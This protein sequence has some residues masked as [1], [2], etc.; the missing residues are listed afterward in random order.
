MKFFTGIRLVAALIF[1]P[2]ALAAHARDFDLTVGKHEVLP[3]KVL[4]EDRDLLI[5]APQKPVPNMPLLV[6]LDGEWNFRKV[7]VAAENL[8][9]NNLLPPTV[10]VGVANTNRGRDLM[11]SFNGGEFAQGPSDRFLSFLADELIPH[12]AAE[13]SI[14]KFHILAGHSN[15]GMFSLYA[16]IRRPEVFQANIVLS[17]SYGLDDHFVALLARALASP[18]AEQHFVFIGAGGDEEADI[19]VG[20]MR[21]AKTFEGAP[22]PAIE[23]HYEIFPGETHGSVGFRAFYRALEAIG[24]ADT[25]AHSGPARYLSEAQRRR[26]AWTRRFGSA[27]ETQP[28]PL[29]SVAR[30]LLDALAAS[31][32]GSLASTWQLLQSDYKDDF[33]FDS[34]ERANLLAALEA[35]GKKEDA[36]RLRSLPGFADGL[37]AAG[38]V[39]NDYGDA[40]HLDVGLVA[41]LPLAGPPAD[42][43]HPDSKPKI[44]GAVPAPDRHDKAD[45][46]WRFSGN[47]D[48]LEFPANPD[49]ATADSV[50]VSAWIR[51]HSPS[52]YTAWVSQVSSLGWGSQWRMGFGPTPTS[53][54]GATTFNGRWSDYLVNG[55]GLPVDKW[56]HT[57]AVFDQTL[58][59]LHVYLDGRELQTFHGIA[60]WAASKGPIL[61]GAQRD[62]GVFFNGDVSDVR[63]YRRALNAKEVEALS[64][65]DDTASIPSAGCRVPQVSNA[66]QVQ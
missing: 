59:E 23:Y 5:A 58:G 49:Y 30:P 38:L 16:F 60:P 20:A 11:P 43:C 14:G 19:S 42:L 62:D 26:H 40:A 35:R 18:P 57:T 47:G 8:T 32:G 33:R 39:P 50:T 64:R 41:D 22:S 1:L 9:A 61:I 56:V 44:Q 17:P 34:V 3:S 51:P 55:D 63:V 24:Q 37:D 28:L 13:Y 65:L 54:W 48:Y 36:E 10:V 15:A 12:I 27:F 53:Q 4:N 2:T 45:G 52:A 6:V 66:L 21:F 46:A 25:P 7:A 31:D 29:L